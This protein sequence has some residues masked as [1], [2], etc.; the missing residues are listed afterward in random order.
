MENLG[1][2]KGY[3]YAHDFPDARVEQEHFPQSLRGQ[4]Y[5]FPTDRGFEAELKKRQKKSEKEPE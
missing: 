2:G 5:Y 1:Y 3:K 4:K